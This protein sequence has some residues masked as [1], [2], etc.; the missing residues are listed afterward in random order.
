VEVTANATT[1]KILN[2]L[3]VLLFRMVEQQFMRLKN[4]HL[5]LETVSGTV[6]NKLQFTKVCVH[7]VP[8]MIADNQPQDS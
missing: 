5:L 8:K 6:N 1:D 2:W 7:W 3:R 4:C